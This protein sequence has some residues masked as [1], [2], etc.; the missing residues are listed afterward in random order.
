[1]RY[2]CLSAGLIIAALFALTVTLFTAMLVLDER[3]RSA[4]KYDC[5]VCLGGGSTGSSGTGGDAKGSAAEDAPTDRGNDSAKAPATETPADISPGSAARGAGMRTHAR[6]AFV[7]Y[8]DCIT[9]PAVALF[10]IACF[11][12][13]VPVAFL[14][15]VPSLQIGVEFEDK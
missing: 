11:V 14:V 3:R 12:A 15:A 2:F 6:A 5:L 13:A 9:Q 10:V 1:V 7:A 4:R 8:G